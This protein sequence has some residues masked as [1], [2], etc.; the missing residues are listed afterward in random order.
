MLRGMPYVGRKLDDVANS[1]DRLRMKEP[2]DG[3]QGQQSLLTPRHDENQ[4]RLWF[5]SSNNR[6]VSVGSMSALP[7]PG[8][9]SISI[10][11]RFFA[12]RLEDFFLLTSHENLLSRFKEC[13]PLVLK[14]RT[15][16]AM[17]LVGN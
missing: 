7:P 15:A 5:M 4:P 9:C 13:A 6:S 3:E 10:V 2:S 12:V 11:N 1:I 16:L 17:A 8:A 14:K